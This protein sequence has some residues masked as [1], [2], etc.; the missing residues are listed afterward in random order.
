MF[1]FILYKKKWRHLGI[2]FMYDIIIH[3][4]QQFWGISYVTANTD[5]ETIFTDKSR[6]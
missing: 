3:K 4:N 1:L 6:T 2:S 5:D